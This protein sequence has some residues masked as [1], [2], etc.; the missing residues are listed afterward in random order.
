MAGSADN[1]VYLKQRATLSEPEAQ[2]CDRCHIPEV[3]GSRG[4]GCLSC[5][6]AVGNQG[7]AEGALVHD[8]HGPVRGPTGAAPGA[9]HDSARGGFLLDASLCGTCHQHDAAPALSLHT[10]ADWEQ[11]GVR[12]SCQ[13]CHMSPRPGRPRHEAEPSDH[14]F[15]G[16]SSPQ[17]EELVG[18]ALRLDL[19][20]QGELVEVE[21]RNQLRAHAVPAG[22]GTVRE[23]WLELLGPEGSDRIPLSDQA[24]WRG[25]PTEELL[26]ADTVEAHRLEPGER[27][28][29]ELD[30]PDALRA[31]L[32]LSTADR[33]HTVDCAEIG[34]R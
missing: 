3:G 10:Y 30:H 23:L 13:D 5:H 31:C 32:R 22:L 26:Q 25:E 8:L 12:A 21:V 7:T 6:A 14:R 9:P 19:R 20:R 11:S 28:V 2:A 4:I 27:R 16:W 17:V 24:L 33:V 15:V 1:P 34:G 18:T 29:Y